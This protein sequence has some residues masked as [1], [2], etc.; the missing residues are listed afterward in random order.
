MG[1]PASID[2]A[3]VPALTALVA[4]CSILSYNQVHVF[5]TYL[6]LSIYATLRYSFQ[7]ADGTDSV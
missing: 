5:I 7:Y 4:S 3:N 1:F 6:M 2:C